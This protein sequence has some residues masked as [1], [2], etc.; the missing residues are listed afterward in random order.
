MPEFFP[1]PYYNPHYAKEYIDSL[2]A[3]F[4]S[5]P[6]KFE[7]NNNT[8]Q[9]PIH[10]PFNSVNQNPDGVASTANYDPNLIGPRPDSSS[11]NGTTK[12]SFGQNLKNNLP[13]AS[14]MAMG[15]LSTIG[16]NRR[17][18]VTN[19]Y[20]QKRQRRNEFDSYTPSYYNPTYNPTAYYQTGNESTGASP[21][22]SQDMWDYIPDNWYGDNKGTLEEPTEIENEN[23][24]NLQQLMDMHFKRVSLND[25]DEDEDYGDYGDWAQPANISMPQDRMQRA[26]LAKNYLQEQGLD[27]DTASAVVGNLLQESGLNTTAN[28]DGGTSFGIA[29]W[30]KGRR[31]GLFNYA[32]EAGKNPHDMYT[33]L[34]YLVKETRRG[35]DWELMKKLPTIADKTRYFSQK[36]ESPSIPHINNRIAYAHSVAGIK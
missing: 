10:G 35:F 26:A 28:G 14:Y 12:P 13:Y 32:Q 25:E 20:N 8:E 34:E 24:Y 11:Y 29:Q 19:E 21:E 30:H 36:W 6:Y 9:E 7:W 27:H 17:L 15:L 22:E 1:D 16:K 4:V 33:Q 23:E 3:G 5:N 2:Y 18:Q 31:D